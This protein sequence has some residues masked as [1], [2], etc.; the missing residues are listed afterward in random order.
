MNTDMED[1]IKTKNALGADDYNNFDASIWDINGCKI[2]FTKLLVW[3]NQNQESISIANNNELNKKFQVEFNKQIRVSKIP[4][5]RKSIL[6]NVLNNVL[7]VSDF[8]IELRNN[9]SAF[10]TLA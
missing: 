4:G 6:L 1:F 8:D 5:L 3:L 10:E 9:F 7:D 2:I